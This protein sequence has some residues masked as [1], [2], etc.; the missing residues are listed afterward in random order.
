MS[1]LRSRVW[2]RLFGSKQFIIP[3]AVA[4]GTGCIAV[5]SGGVWIAVAT[6]F[7]LIATGS[8]VLKLA[9][10]AEQL[11]KVAL[12]D[13][14]ND[15]RSQEDQRLNDLQ[16]R[17]RSDRDFRTKDCFQLASQART[18]FYSLIQKAQGNFA[19]LQFGQQ[20]DQLFWVTI[21]QLEH[22]LQLYER[23]DRLV[24]ARRK[25]ILAEREHVVEDLIGAADRLRQVVD[26]I[27]STAMHDREA[28]L[29]SLSKELDDSLEIA[30]RVDQRLTELESEPNRDE[31]LKQ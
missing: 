7:A 5:I 4:V 10:G 26:R 2:R 9:A 23:A 30:K 1:D 17:L 19:F 20:F 16:K 13:Q 27:R 14:I 29:N 18:D 8:V 24:D 12:N 11:E 28:E 6:A 15:R 21:E 22:S 3:A 31:F 25:E